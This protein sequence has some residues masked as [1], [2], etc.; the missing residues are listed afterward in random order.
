MKAWINRSML[1]A[2]AFLCAGAVWAQGQAADTEGDFIYRLKKA[3]AEVSVRGTSTIGHWDCSQN[4]IDG[5][6]RINVSAKALRESLAVLLKGEPKSPS[7]NEMWKD[8]ESQVRVAV[9]ANNFTCD[10]KRMKRDLEEV[11]QADKYPSINFWFSKIVGEGTIESDKHGAYLI[12]KVEG[13]LLFGG[14]RRKTRHTAEIRLSEKNLIEVKGKL[15]LEMTD[16]GIKPPTALFGLIRANNNFQVDYWIKI[17]AED[18]AI[19]FEDGS[20]RL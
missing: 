16:F 4:S 18:C 12:L 2:A 5:L 9:D 8:L 7:L 19:V 13:D 11:I 15:D 3:P 20:R 17:K 10:N 14:Q 6:A 1:L